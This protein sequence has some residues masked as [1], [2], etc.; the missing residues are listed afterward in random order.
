MNYGLDEKKLLQY[1]EKTGQKTVLLR[2]EGEYY[3]IRLQT[4]PSWQWGDEY[5]YVNI[6]HLPPQLN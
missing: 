5:N 4:Q 2:H 3:L 1:L 6:E